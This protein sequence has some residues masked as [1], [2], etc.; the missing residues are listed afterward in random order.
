MA[1]G[2]V[3]LVALVLTIASA[4]CG[5]FS[6]VTSA[7]PVSSIPEVEGQ[8]TGTFRTT[9][10]T[11]ST[12][13]LEGYCGLVTGTDPIAFVLTLA[14]IEDELVGSLQIADVLVPLSGTIDAAGRMRMS[15]SASAP[16]EGAGTVT[17]AIVDWDTTAS[18]TSLTGGWSS[19][20]DASATGDTAQGTHVIVEAV[21]TG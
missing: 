3:P 7:D 19:Q 20:A 15:G 13:V 6:G 21:K 8:W 4:G 9:A 16:V 12:P 10:C 14:Q 1:T 18:G 17:V 5:L 2:H 11:V